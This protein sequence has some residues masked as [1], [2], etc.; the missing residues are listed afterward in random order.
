MAFSRCRRLTG[1]AAVGQQRLVESS[2]ARK[3]WPAV[4]AAERHQRIVGQRRAVG[5]VGGGGAEKGLEQLAHGALGQVAG[6]EHQPAAVVVVRPAFQ[7]RG[8]VE[9]VLHAVHHH[10]RVGHFGEL[11]DAL[12]AQELVAM[13]RAQQLEEHSSVPAGMAASAVSTK[14]ADVLVVAVGVMMVVVVMRMRVGIGLGGEPFL[15]V[16]DLALRIVQ[17]AVE[18]P[19]R[20]RLA[21]GCIEDRRR[22][23]ERAQALD[24]ALALPGAR[25]IG[26]GQHD[27]V[28]DRRLLHRFRVLHRASHRR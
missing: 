26:L 14:D 3:A 21:L 6:D 4:D 18:Q 22:R 24:H 15:H 28:G 8:R 7:P 10:R 19:L 16:G 13:S 5:P 2:G 12:E 25:Q 27:A 9:D 20:R 17:P 23:I 1:T 11:H